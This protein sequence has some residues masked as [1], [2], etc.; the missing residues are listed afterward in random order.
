MGVGLGPGRCVGVGV[1]EECSV[2]LGIMVAVACIGRL[3]REGVLVS[4]RIGV[5]VNSI[6]SVGVG[7]PR[8]PATSSEEAIIRNSRRVRL[9]MPSRSCY[10]IAQIH[11]PWK[12]A[13]VI[14]FQKITY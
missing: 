5:A 10:I 4:G 12:V 1:G 2:A 14:I 8:H 13:N 6:V 7:A 9:F 11:S 3:V